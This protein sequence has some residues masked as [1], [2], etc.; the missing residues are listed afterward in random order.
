MRI[1]HLSEQHLTA[2]PDYNTVAKRF[3]PWDGMTADDWGGAWVQVLPGETSTPHHHEENEVFFVVRGSGVLRHGEEEHR[4][5][6]G[7]SMYMEPGTEHCLTNDGDE[8]LLF[9]SIWWDKPVRLSAD[10]GH[11]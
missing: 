7:S 6:F 8:P 11:G 2:E 5:G 10:P 9:V 1:Y 4:V 3:F